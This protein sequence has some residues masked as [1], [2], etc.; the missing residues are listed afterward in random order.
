[1][2]LRFLGSECSIGDYPRL[3]S[4]GQTIEL[5]EALAADAI[6]GGAALLPDAQFDA[7]G[8]TDSELSD[9]GISAS[10]QFAPA[11]FLAKK[12]AGLIAIHEIRE[13]GFPVPAPA[14]A[15]APAPVDVQMFEGGE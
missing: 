13:N 1:M 14:P 9:Y 5:D 4:F 7:L 11:E 3:E 15:P 6:R 2:K 10:H 12:R 8:F